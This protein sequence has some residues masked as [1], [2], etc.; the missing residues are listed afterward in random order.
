M[1]V[2]WGNGFMTAP[3][4]GFFAACRRL[5]FVSPHPFS[6]LAARAGMPVRQV[7]RL[8]ARTTHPLIDRAALALA[9]MGWSLMARAGDGRWTVLFEGSEGAAAGGQ[10][11]GTVRLAW[12]SWAEGIAAACA[13]D[14]GRLSAV[15]VREGISRGLATRLGR[16]QLP[17]GFRQLV[18]LL[19]A[20]DQRVV[21]IDARG[22]AGWLKLDLP[23]GQPGL[24][25][26]PM[27]RCPA[28]CTR[29]TRPAGCTGTSCL[30]KGMILDLYRNRGL[31]CKTIAQLAGISRER[32]RQIIVQLGGTSPRRLRVAR[33]ISAFLGDGDAGSP[34][35]GAQAAV[36]PP[37][38]R[39]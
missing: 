35:Q 20:A 1:S 8:H 25:I 23:T 37:G 19:G 39:Q 6:E 7:R 22:Q 14:A 4:I 29:K 28:V 33:R 10:G 36:L 13:L 31:D 32:V 30:G 5:I 34:E 21:V 18:H 15:L 27:V 3:E 26:R 24:G 9:L 2:G 12:T 11:G 38:L 16:G 17:V